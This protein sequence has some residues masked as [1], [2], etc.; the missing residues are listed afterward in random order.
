MVDNDSEVF[1][2]GTD[3]SVRVL[4]V[5]VDVDATFA[6]CAG[7][8]DPHV[9]REGKNCC[10]VVDGVHPNHHD[11]VAAFAVVSPL[12]ETAGVRRILGNARIVVGAGDEEV[13]CRQISLWKIDVAIA[14]VD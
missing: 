8:S 4:L 13:L 12:A 5:E 7:L 2:D 1:F 14:L 11:G 6:C 3:Q 9:A 10:L